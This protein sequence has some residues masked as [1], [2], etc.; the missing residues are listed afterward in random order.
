MV[1]LIHATE[2]GINTLVPLG[3]LPSPLCNSAIKLISDTKKGTKQSPTFCSVVGVYELS[4]LW[5]I[6]NE[7]LKDLVEDSVI[8]CL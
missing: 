4:L 3:S 7:D 8:Q 1:V 2:H 6:I 5:S